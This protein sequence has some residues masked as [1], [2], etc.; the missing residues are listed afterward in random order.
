[1]RTRVA[2]LL[3]LAC[4]A[5]QGGC[6]KQVMLVRDPPAPYFGPRVAVALPMP[7]RPAAG[8]PRYTA[9]ELPRESAR[10]SSWSTAAWRPAGPERPW[11]FIVI[12][13]SATATGSAG[14][15]DRMHRAKGWD[16][17]GYH[18]VIGNGTGSGDGEVEVG[19]RWPVQKH[20]AH[21]K[22]ANHPEYNDLGIGICLVGNFDVT[23]PTEAQMQ[24]L[25]RLVRFLRDRYD[26]SRGRM[27]GHG[28][29]KPTDC[30]G[31]KFDYSDFFRRL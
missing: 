2:A 6:Q 9:I 17:L 27:Y 21:T 5:A 24:S 22:V 12:H 16:E 10:S 8:Q 11:R 26:I 25:M 28:Q 7:S 1:M 14:E 4:L 20:G 19:G 15:F 29:L 3:L 31:L 30:P 13:H 18:F 23:R